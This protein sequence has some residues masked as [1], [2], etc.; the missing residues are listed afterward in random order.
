MSVFDEGGAS[1]FDGIDLGT[2]MRIGVKEVDQ[3]HAEL[4]RLIERINEDPQALTS[5]ESVTDLLGSL[6]NVLSREF[7][8]EEKLMVE[9]KAP[10]DQLA[11]H[12]REHTALLSLF[13]DASIDAMSKK[14]STAR[15]LY[16][17]IKSKVLEHTVKHDVRLS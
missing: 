11:E 14:P 6:Q 17:T 12:I 15:Q 3:L 7:D 1:G 10:W 4:A 2:S 5:S 8:I 16:K 9:N 13:V